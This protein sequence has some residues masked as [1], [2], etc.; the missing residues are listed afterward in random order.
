V[1]FALQQDAERT[2]EFAST[3]FGQR[4]SID[5]DL[6]SRWH[7]EP[8]QG[9]QQR[10]FAAAVASKHGPQFAGRYGQL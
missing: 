7:G 1:I 9:M 6:T 4:T 10:G 3:V 5:V 2:P 8:G